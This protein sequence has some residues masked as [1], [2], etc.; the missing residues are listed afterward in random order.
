MVGM[1]AALDFK[2]EKWKRNPVSRNLNDKQNYQY[3]YHFVSTL[4]A[5]KCCLV[6]NSVF[7]V[8][9]TSWVDIF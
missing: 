7:R 6:E 3:A 9:E 8:N 5:K 1:G 2:R 4:P